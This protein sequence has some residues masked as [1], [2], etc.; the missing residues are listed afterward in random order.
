M[1]LCTR[2]EIFFLKAEIAQIFYINF[3]RDDAESKKFFVLIIKK[4]DMKVAL[5]FWSVIN[6]HIV[7]Y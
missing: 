1:L 4:R 7:R 6:K 5:I 3:A 2:R